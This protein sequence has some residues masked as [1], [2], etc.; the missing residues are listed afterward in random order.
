M[1]VVSGNQTLD[2]NELAAY[3]EFDVSATST[4]SLQFGEGSAASW[5]S[6][7]VTLYRSNNRKRWDALATPTT[8]TGFGFTDP[9]DTSDFLFLRA[10][11]TTVAGAAGLFDVA[12]C[13]KG[14]E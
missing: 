10:E 5:G 2:A 1:K 4:G 7:V 13:F 12:P 8:V 3:V 9:I 6:T 14:E 11:V